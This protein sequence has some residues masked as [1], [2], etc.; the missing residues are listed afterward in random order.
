M[1]ALLR[2]A[3]ALLLLLVLGV[4]AV[5]WLADTSVGHRFIADRIEAL[6][7]ASGLRV[8][9]G[10]IEGSIY[11]ATRV[12]D[13]RLSDSKGQ[14]FQAGQVSVD[15]SPMAWLSNRL[16]MIGWCRL[17]QPS[18]ACLHW[19]RARPHSRFCRPSIFVSAN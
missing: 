8:K 3:G 17:Q 16:D 15:W 11:G 4:L 2:W 12:R 19:C 9:V 10:R 13:L 18:T 5:I 6:R 1:R 14:F 7:P